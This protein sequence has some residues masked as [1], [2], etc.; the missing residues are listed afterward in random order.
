MVKVS[1]KEVRRGALAM[2]RSAGVR[3]EVANAVVDNVIEAEILG[4]GSHGLQLVP[5]Y[6]SGIK[7]GEVAPDAVVEI[8][9]NAR[10]HLSVNGR[11]GF[12]H[13]AVSQAF[14]KAV[15]D[16]KQNRVCFASV[17]NIGHCGRLGQY[18]RIATE[19]N[20]I[21][22]LCAGFGNTPHS[23]TVAPFGGRERMLGSN[24]IAV[25]VPTN[26]SVPF[27]IDFSTSAISFY[28]LKLIEQI[29]G[30]LPESCLVDR[31]GSASID[32]K[33]FYDGGALLPFAGH[34]GFGISLLVC[35]LIALS[36]QVDPLKA[37]VE[38]A[39]IQV[40]DLESLTDVELYKKGI[41]AF[42]DTVRSSASAPA[43]SGVRIPGDRL[44]AVQGQTDEAWIDVSEELRERLAH[45]CEALGIIPWF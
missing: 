34:K 12:G 17:F 8:G 35:L 18:V 38:G 28:K 5:D 14:K 15:Q 9:Q 33:D 13:Y 45:W 42:L 24:P 25:G 39:F 21:G 41:T 27:V 6:L 36:G 7:N 43:S 4:Y 11:N 22:I 37:Q 29:G 3:E 23:A 31:S 44:R 10:G 2:L 30:V 40:I 32:P 26:D 19:E 1:G 16:A 20:C